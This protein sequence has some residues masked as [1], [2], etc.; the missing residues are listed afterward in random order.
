MNP[1]KINET[2]HILC[3][4]K[5]T[6]FFLSVVLAALWLGIL[7]VSH[8]N[9]KKYNPIYHKSVTD[10]HRQLAK[11]H[12]LNLQDYSDEQIWKI[13]EDNRGF[14][15]HKEDEEAFLNA[16]YNEEIEPCSKIE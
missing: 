3:R 6:F 13:I 7:I 14:A 15:T 11:E 2:H 5:R 4:A 10:N 12:N 9:M 1:A 16:L 8:T